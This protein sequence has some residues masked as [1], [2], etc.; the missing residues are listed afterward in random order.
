[1]PPWIEASGDGQQYLSA[2]LALSP[3]KFSSAGAGV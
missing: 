3:L 1:M 2:V